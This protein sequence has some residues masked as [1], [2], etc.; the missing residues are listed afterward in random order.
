MPLKSDCL[1]FDSLKLHLKQ[2]CSL[3]NYKSNS[4]ELF[5][6]LPEFLLEQVLNYPLYQTP[7]SNYNVFNYNFPNF[8]ICY[9]TEFQDLFTLFKNASGL[10]QLKD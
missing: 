4:E 9:K 7:K 2:V 10:D 1:R 5:G 3:N 6:Y 8:F